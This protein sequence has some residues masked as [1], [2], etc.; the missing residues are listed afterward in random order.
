MIHNLSNK[1]AFGG[2]LFIG[3]SFASTIILNKYLRTNSYFFFPYYDKYHPKYS[4]INGFIIP[5][6]IKSFY[7]QH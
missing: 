6:P 7:Q 4:T 3:F 1:Y 2:F 5:Y